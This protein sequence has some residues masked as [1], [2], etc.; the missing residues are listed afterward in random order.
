VIDEIVDPVLGT[1]ITKTTDLVFQKR[2]PKLLFENLGESNKSGPTV[3]EKYA[4]N[5]D[6]DAIS[7]RMFNLATGNLQTIRAN[8]AEKKGIVYCILPHSWKGSEIEYGF[9]EKVK[10]KHQKSKQNHKKYQ[11]L[12][13]C[14]NDIDMVIAECVENIKRLRQ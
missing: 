13:S 14:N 10:E 4:T 3:M 6:H 9:V 5:I 8:K 7:F 11:Y 2:H 12:S 1:T